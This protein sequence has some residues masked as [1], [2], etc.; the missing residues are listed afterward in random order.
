MMRLAWVVICVASQ[1]VTPLDHRALPGNSSRKFGAHRPFR[2]PKEC[3]RGHCGV[4]LGSTLGDPV[5]AVHDGVVERIERDATRAPRS[6]RYVRLSHEDG[7]VVSRYIHLDSIRDDLTVGD[8][9]K[10]G[11]LIGRLGSTGIY[12]TGPHLHFSLSLRDGKG[13]R[14]VDPEP[15]LRKWELPAWPA[16]KP[17]PLLASPNP[18]ARWIPEHWLW[19]DGRWLRQPAAWRIPRPGPPRFVAFWVE[20][21]WR[22][23]G[24]AWMWFPAGWRV[25]NVK[26]SVNS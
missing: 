10:S 25:Q 7:T 15:F 4:D 8:R 19:V 24:L 12:S 26:P 6:G 20:G 11:E 17:A 16:P 13:E 21:H 3:R 18:K 14:Y 1:W 2:R 22:W 5:F 9:V 23:S